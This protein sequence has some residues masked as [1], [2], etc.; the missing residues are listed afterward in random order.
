L[1][2]AAVAGFLAWGTL[3][4]Q[5]SRP[6]R[7]TAIPNRLSEFSDVRAICS[8]LGHS[9]SSYTSGGGGSSGMHATTRSYD[10]Q[11]DLPLQLRGQFMQSYRQ[12]VH[13]LLQKESNSVWGAGS[14]SDGQGLR[15]FDFEYA[16]GSTRGTVAVRSASGDEGLTLLIFVHE[17]QFQP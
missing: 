13:A 15:G 9:V 17:H 10:M 7:Q 6:Y 2:T 3:L 5:R 14:M 11:I 8:A 4:Y 1:L 12:H 16:K